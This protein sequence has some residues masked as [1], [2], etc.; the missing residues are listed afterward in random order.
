MDARAGLRRRDRRH[1]AGPRR[2]A[3]STSGARATSARV[4]TLLADLRRPDP[5]VGARQLAD[6]PGR[7]PAGGA[8]LLRRAGEGRASAATSRPAWS[9]P[10]WPRP[11]SSRCSSRC[12]RSARRTVARTSAPFLVLTPAA[13]F[14]AVSADALFA[15]VVAWGLACLALGATAAARGRQVGWSALAGLL[16]GSAR[17]DVLRPAAGR[18]ARASPCWSSRGRG[19]RSRSPAVT[20]LAVVLAFA[21]GGL[22]VVGGLPGAQ[23]PLL[24]RHR[25]RPPG[26][27]LDVGQPRRARRLRR[28]DARRRA[29]GSWSPQRRRA[30]RVVLLLVSAAA[31]AIVLADVSRMSKAEV[32]RIWLPFV[33]WL[34][35]S[36]A[37][38]PR[39]VAAL[40]RCSSRSSARWWCSSCSTRAGDVPL[41]R[42]RM[43]TVRERLVT[44]RA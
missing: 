26:V 20:A 10:C 25:R 37:L 22:L 5:D 7:S 39:A 3:T 24:G 1:L 17:D 42:S 29:S 6:A 12:G 44:V 9:S 38:L 41:S 21:A 31:T 11:P 2:P 36:V 4:H 40:G 18:A 33:P 28:P 35:L 23:R 27:V 43:V 34:M 13:V 30:D 16:L 19:C 14:M 15:A 8:A 32:E